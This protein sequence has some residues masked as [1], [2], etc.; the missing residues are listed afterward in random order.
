MTK[1]EQDERELDTLKLFHGIYKRVA[2]VRVSKHKDKINVPADISE[3]AEAL[4]RYRN[5]LN[6]SMDSNDD[7]VAFVVYSI[8]MVRAFSVFALND[9]K[10]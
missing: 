2:S 5:L 1:I 7:L 8:N 4:S 9:S 6:F 10:N 3:I